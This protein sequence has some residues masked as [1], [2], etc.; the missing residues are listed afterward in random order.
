M[1]S[2]PLETGTSLKNVHS[3]V[4]QRSKTDGLSSA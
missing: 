3:S 1:E 2:Q 4:T